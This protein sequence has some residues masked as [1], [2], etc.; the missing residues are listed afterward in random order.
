MGVRR[1]ITPS[2]ENTIPQNGYLGL[3]GP[4]PNQR[5]DQICENLWKILP[6]QLCYTSSLAEAYQALENIVKDQLRNIDWSCPISQRYF[7]T[8]GWKEVRSNAAKRACK[9]H[10]TWTAI[11]E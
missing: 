1:A 3:L 8:S 7:S 9:V 6:S 5:M 4:H 2:K 10:R 11:G